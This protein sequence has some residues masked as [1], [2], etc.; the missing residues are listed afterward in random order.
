MA[1]LR[2]LWPGVDGW[3]RL[4]A[5]GGG[6]EEEEEEEG[7]RATWTTPGTSRVRVGLVAWLVSYVAC[8]GSHIVIGMVAFVAFVAFFQ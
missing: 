8:V 6:C 4:R 3:M 2:V 1:G 5:Q 7:S